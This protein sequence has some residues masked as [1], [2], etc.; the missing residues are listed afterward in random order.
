MRSLRSKISVGAFGVLMM[1]SI[2]S[3]ASAQ[4]QPD[5][6][7][8]SESTPGVSLPPNEPHGIVSDT[9]DRFGGLFGPMSPFDKV[10]FVLVVILTLTGFLLIA[11]RRRRR[12]D[13]K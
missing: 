4:Y 2:A 8:P 13:E 10:G 11:A 7:D 9:P 12:S 6:V 5:L 3:A 1:L